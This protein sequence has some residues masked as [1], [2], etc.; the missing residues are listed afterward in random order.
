MIGYLALL[1][2]KLLLASP[3]SHDIILPLLPGE[4]KMEKLEHLR[5]SLSELGGL[6]RMVRSK[7]DDLDGEDRGDE[8]LLGIDSSESLEADRGVLQS[9]IDGLDDLIMSSRP[10][11]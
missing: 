9:A 11:R 10:V 3:T 6:Q 5:S 2:T 4:T 1:L 8:E 7:L